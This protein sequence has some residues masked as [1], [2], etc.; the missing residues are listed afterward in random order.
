MAIAPA[1][2]PHSRDRNITSA[3]E[4][5]NFQKRKVINT[6]VAF[7]IENKATR[8]NTITNNIIIAKLFSGLFQAPMIYFSTLFYLSAFFSSMLL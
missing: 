4:A 6:G 7:C 3:S 8:T 1:M 2:I 5:S